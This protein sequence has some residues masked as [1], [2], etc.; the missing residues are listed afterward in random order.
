MEHWLFNNPA[1][2]MNHQDWSM[3]DDAVLI[4][5]FDVKG[6]PE[7]Q[8][9]LLPD[10]IT[11]YENCQRYWYNSLCKNSKESDGGSMRIKFCMPRDKKA[12]HFSKCPKCAAYEASYEHAD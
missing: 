10:K 6:I 4:H 2:L 11:V 3:L 1:T 12:C 5:H 7:L 9:F 8:S